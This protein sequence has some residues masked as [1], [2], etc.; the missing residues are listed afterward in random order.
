M[1]YIIIAIFVLIPI[2]EISLFI[3][4]G[5]IIGSFYTI[6]LIFLTAIVGVFFVRQQ[7]ISTF[8]KL[9]SQLQKFE[10]PVQTMFEG[11]V[12]LIAGILL[13]TPGF[14]TDALGFLGLIPVSRII[15]IKLVASYMLSRY[16][17]HKI[18]Y[19]YT[20]WLIHIQDS[21]VYKHIGDSLIIG[22][23]FMSTSYNVINIWHKSWL[24][25]SVLFRR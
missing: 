13:I 18:T 7:G 25:V 4:I 11:L 1:F 17:V 14:F 9:A 23:Y 21:I 6:M 19:G 15:F 16:I 10:T 3:E 8:Q 2:I 5:S 12:I 22:S 20:F 24:I